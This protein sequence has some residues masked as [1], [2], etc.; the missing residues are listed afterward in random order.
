MTML[1]GNTVYVTAVQIKQHIST[2]EDFVFLQCTECSY[3]SP[4][5]VRVGYPKDS[6]IDVLLCNFYSAVSCRNLEIM[7][8]KIALNSLNVV[9]F[10]SED[11]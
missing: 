10:K 2:L 7:L 8:G 3:F 11:R 9:R 5:A 1:T 6:W 4:V